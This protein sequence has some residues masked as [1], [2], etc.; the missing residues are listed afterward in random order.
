MRPRGKVNTI[1]GPGK[2]FRS[3]F[4]STPK[5]GSDI[6]STAFLEFVL[7]ISQFHPIIK[8]K[9]KS[10]AQSSVPGS[11]HSSCVTSRVK[12]SRLAGAPPRRR[13]RRFPG[14]LPGAV[15]AA[16]GQAFKPPGLSP[17]RRTVHPD[18]PGNHRFHRLGSPEVTGRRHTAD[19]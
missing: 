13:S 9:G 4:S 6:S 7:N 19:P 5:R 17:P 8:Y 1:D 2:K 11:C 12:V 14:S 18:Q 3:A 15:F 10:Q 16:P